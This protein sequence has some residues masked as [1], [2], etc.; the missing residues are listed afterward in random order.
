MELIKHI[1]ETFKFNDKEIRV[2]GTYDEPWFV[3]K[4]ICDILGLSQVNK[5]ILNIPEKWKSSEILNTSTRG[6]QTM[7]VLQETA[8]YT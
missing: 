7:I 3:A 4:D 2:I 5:A 6:K 1:D 8:V